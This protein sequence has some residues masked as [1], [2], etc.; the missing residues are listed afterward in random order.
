MQENDLLEKIDIVNAKNVPFA[1]WSLPGSTEWEGIAQLSNTRYFL[2]NN[3]EE[4]FLVA[5]F[6]T[7]GRFEL[8]KPNIHFTKDSKIPS[9]LE[10]MT[11]HHDIVKNDPFI[12]SHE[13]YISQCGLLIR[14][15]NKDYI[16]KVVLSRVLKKETKEKASIIFDKMRL[17]YPDAMVFIYRSKGQLWIGASPETYIVNKGDE[18]TTMALA[19]T[20]AVN[21]KIAWT[22]KER[23][24]Q[25]YV[26]EYIE[27]LLRDEGITFTKTGPE[28]VSAG[29]ILHLQ[30]KYKGNLGTSKLLPLLN[31][32]HPTPAVCGIP[33]EKARKMI[34]EIEKHDRMDYTGFLGPLNKKNVQLFVNLRSGMIQGKNLY[35]FIGGGITKDS[36]A[37]EEWKETELKAQ[38]LLSI[39]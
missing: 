2:D 9:E 6:L 28:T 16:D 8:I 10:S 12:V 15:L 5:P 20:K 34:L 39:L 3:L 22:K 37:E 25:H 32:L 24:E 29:P 17:A 27:E 14:E 26:E 23:D 35:L 33:R 30:S 1:F 7:D 21:S 19:G 11:D 4:G 38:T 36:I 18:I 31:K 13:A